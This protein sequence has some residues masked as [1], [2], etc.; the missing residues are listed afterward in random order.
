MDA[1]PPQ[2]QVGKKPSSLYSAKTIRTEGTLAYLWL[3]CSASRVAERVAWP[4]QLSHSC[5]DPGLRVW[6][7]SRKNQVVPCW[8]PIR[9]GPSIKI[10]TPAGRWCTLPSAKM[11]AEDGGLCVTLRTLMPSL[12]GVN[13]QCCISQ[14][15]W[16]EDVPFRNFSMSEESPQSPVAP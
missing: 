1:P 14:L 3:H 2:L 15:P 12:W 13:S 9:P 8:F 11:G 5:G 16:L 4:L 10:R 7:R 6:S